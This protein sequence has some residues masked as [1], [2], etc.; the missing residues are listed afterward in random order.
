MYS[1]VME[2]NPTSYIEEK[3]WSSDPKLKH[4]TRRQ[5][6]FNPGRGCGCKGKGNYITLLNHDSCIR[7]RVDTTIC[8]VCDVI[9]DIDIVR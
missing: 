3:V 1:S 7:G 9:V 6:T 2:I 4:W 8:T 5:C